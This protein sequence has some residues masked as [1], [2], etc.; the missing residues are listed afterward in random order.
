MN[1]WQRFDSF[2]C[3]EPNDSN[4]S[5]REKK[6]LKQLF[7]QLTTAICGGPGPSRKLMGGAERKSVMSCT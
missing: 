2:H 1:K 7:K 6:I 5:L 4:E 3:T